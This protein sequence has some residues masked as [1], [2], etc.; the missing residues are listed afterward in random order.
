MMIKKD[1]FS[2]WPI[3]LLFSM[4]WLKVL[5][6]LYMDIKILKKEFLHSYLEE[7]KK[8]LDKWEGEDSDQILTFV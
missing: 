7:L 3:S 1:S 8:I 5:L 6:L 4:T 2:V